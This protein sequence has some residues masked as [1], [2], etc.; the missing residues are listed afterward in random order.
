MTQ[1]ERRT[2]DGN[3]ER[4]DKRMTELTVAV[5]GMR[6]ATEALAQAFRDDINEVKKQLDRQRRLSKYNRRT[7]F[8]VMAYIFVVG[9]LVSDVGRRYCGYDGQHAKGAAGSACNVVFWT[10]EHGG[11]GL[12]RV[13]GF[14]LQA[15]L[16]FWITKRAQVPADLYPEVAAAQVKRERARPRPRWWPS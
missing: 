1:P 4:L 10:T 12:W 8:Q 6:G 9:L 15:A 13:V 11:G 3:R 7:W 14:T 16:I 2:P 5:V